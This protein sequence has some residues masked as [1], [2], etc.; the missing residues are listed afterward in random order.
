MNRGVIHLNW[1]AV[2]SSLCASRTLRTESASSVSRMASSGFV[3]RTDPQQRVGKSGSLRRSRAPGTLAC[4]STG[5]IARIKSLSIGRPCMRAA[6]GPV[7]IARFPIR[8]AS[9]HASRRSVLVTHS[10]MTT[11]PRRSC[12]MPQAMRLALIP[13][14]T[15]R[16]RISR[17]SIT[18]PWLDA[19]ARNAI[20]VLRCF[21]TRSVSECKA[22]TYRGESAF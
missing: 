9:A 3:R 15:P 20:G 2:S 5:L 17:V 11:T 14:E 12:H 19:I 18:P 1:S 4:L 10:G 16:I 22:Q 6:V 21:G 7:M 13:F 8:R